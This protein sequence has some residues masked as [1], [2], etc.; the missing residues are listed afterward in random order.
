M[1]EMRS[2]KFVRA[3]GPE[4]TQWICICKWIS[5]FVKSWGSSRGRHCLC[6]SDTCKS[7]CI[8]IY[9]SAL[10]VTRVLLLQPTCHWLWWL[11]TRSLSVILS[12]GF[13]HQRKVTILLFKSTY[14][15]ALSFIRRPQQKGASSCLTALW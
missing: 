7:L 14:N 10:A 6:A 3:G 15:K 1:L 13:L 5:P 11:S 8:V 4:R 2:N 9:G 12:L